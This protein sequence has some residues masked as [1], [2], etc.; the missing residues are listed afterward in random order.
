MLHRSTLAYRAEYSRPGHS[1]L[2]YIGLEGVRWRTKLAD[3]NDKYKELGVKACSL[4][5]SL[6]GLIHDAFPRCD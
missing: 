2:K 3:P 4:A 6:P 1:W 5:P